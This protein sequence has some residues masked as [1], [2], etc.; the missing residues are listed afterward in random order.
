MSTSKQLD[1]FYTSLTAS[2]T[3]INFVNKHVNLNEFDNIIEP[4][5]GCGNLLKFLPPRTIGVDLLPEAEGIIQHDF[6]TWKFP[7]GKNVVVGNPPF[8]KS[9][10]LAIEFF[11]HASNN[12][13]VIAFI[14]PVTWE[15]YTIHKHLPMGWGL[16][17]NERLPEK[18][19][20]L[21]GSPYNVRCT[22]QIWTKGVVC[23]DLRLYK[24]PSGVN[25]YFDFVRK[26][27]CEFAIRQAYPK[28]VL[29]KDI[30]KQSHYYIKP[31]VAGVFEVFNSIEWQNE[32]NRKMLGGASVPYLDKDT[33]V[34]FYEKY[35]PTQFNEA[36]NEPTYGTLDFL[37]AA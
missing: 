12:C 6:L 29:K 21:D 11:K 7:V 24:Q 3:F 30:D 15:K 2:E 22:M 34:K 17:V 13:D 36:A 32:E 5:A 18:S 14:I 28:T 25:P 26:D 23:N 27:E 8:G 35:T 31:K 16:V 19:F 4:S 10:K 33:I 1:K 37:F 9:S 20:E